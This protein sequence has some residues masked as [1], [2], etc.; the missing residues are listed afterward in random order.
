M[1]E[2]YLENLCTAYQFSNMNIDE[3]RN[4]ITEKFYNDDS[5]SYEI[6]AEIK[7]IRRKAI[8]V[9]AKYFFLQNEGRVVEFRICS[10]NPLSDIG[11]G[12]Q[13]DNIEQEKFSNDYCLKYCQNNN[14]KEGDNITCR[15]IVQ[16]DPEQIE[17]GN[18]LTFSIESMRHFDYKKI[19]EIYAE[20]KIEYKPG[21]FYQI[22]TESP[23]DFDAIICQDI[24]EKL[25][26]VLDEKKAEIEQLDNDCISFKDLIDLAKSDYDKEISFQKQRL[27]D[28]Y[29]EK[30]SELENIIAAK[31]SQ[32]EQLQ[33]DIDAKRAELNF[34]EALGISFKPPKKNLDEN[35]SVQ[36]FDNFDEMINYWQSHLNSAAHGF[37]QYDKRILESLYFA[38][39]LNQLILLAGNPGTGK[40]SLVKALA[41]SFN[42]SAAKI[43]PVQSN[44]TDKNDL[45]GYYNP[46]EKNY[47]ATPFLDALINFSRQAE[48]FPEKLFIICL[49]EMNLAHVEHYFAEFLSILQDSENA[50]ITLYSEQLQQDILYELQNSGF[51]ENPALES[52][53]LQERKYFFELR[54][55]AN[56]L[57]N[58]PAKFKIPKNVKFFGTL[59]QDETTLDISPKVLDRSYVIRIEKFLDTEKIPRGSETPLHYKPLEN[60]KMSNTEFTY[61]NEFITNFQTEIQNFGLIHIS[62]RVT[63]K[64]LNFTTIN[65]YARI[66]GAEK[67]KD[68]IISS[69]VLPKVRLGE[70]N[71][72]NY[73]AE[74]EKLFDGNL[75][76]EIWQH[77]NSPKDNQADFWRR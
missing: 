26:Q 47:V 5:R 36:D 73:A 22:F 30:K 64:I 33:K 51:T 53:T 21:N 43:I 69:C 60:Y 16:R 32:A 18:Y 10:N 14:F 3:R 68:F 34:L 35:I 45:L 37:L 40:T 48:K 6:I 58:Y 11:S 38:L 41:K 8:F 9:V 7:K 56:M 77:I 20:Y 27:E 44:W 59:N 55:R 50:E 2:I 66:L 67:V 31:N 15:L 74:F 4:Y 19:G 75:S 28:A 39:Q 62:R 70:E 49:D 63:N 25:K 54:R 12:G 29:A 65:S 24:D 46:L 42:F 71:Y 1:V 13:F 57:K 76:R 23:E 72:K 61:D 52:L 17:K